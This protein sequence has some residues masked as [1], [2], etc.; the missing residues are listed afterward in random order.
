MNKPLRF[1]PKCILGFLMICFC[2]PFLVDAQISVG[3]VGTPPTC[4][5]FTN[6]SL[7][8]SASGG[9][10]PYTYTWSNGATGPILIGVGAGVYSVTVVDI[11]LA[12]ATATY[13]LVDPPSLVID[14]I[15]IGNVC[16]NPG[17]IRVNVSGGTAPYTY[18]WSNGSTS[19]TQ[20]GLAPGL[21]CVTV[22]DANGCAK[23]NCFAVGSVLSVDVQTV[24]SQCAMLCDGSAVANVSGGTP[25]YTFLWNTGSTDQLIAPLGP[26]TYTVTVTDANGCVVIGSGIVSE[27]PPIII[28]LNIVQPGCLS[29]NT[30]SI[31]ASATGGVPGYTYTWNTGQTGPVISNLG[32]GTYTLV[33]TD[34]N[35]CSVDTTV[36]IIPGND[37]DLQVT[38]T[39]EICLG[40][41]NGTATATA[42]GGTPP[43]TF[44]WS[45]G[46]SG[47][48]ITGLTPGTYTVTATDQ[49]GCQKSASVTVRAGSAL[50][51][52]ITKS[53]VTVCGGSDGSAS[54][55]VTGGTAP[56]LFTWSNGAT[57]ANITNLQAG[58]YS[59]TVVDQEGCSATGTVQI[60]QPT[61]LSLNLTK[62]D[63]SCFGFNNGTITTTVSGGTA[64][65]TFT[66]SNGANTAS[67]SNLAPGTYSVTVS[68]TGGCSA[69]GSATINQ[70]ASAL[71]CT[72]SVTRQISTPGGN[73]G[74]AAVTAAGGTPPYSNAW[75]NGQT[76]ANAT[77]L[78]AGT[79][80]VTVTDANRCTTV[81]TVTLVDPVP[82][83]GK[84]GDYVWEDK[85][86]NGLQDAT[87]P[88][89]RNVRVVLTGTTNSG[90]AVNRTTFTDVTGMYMFGDLMAG[91]YKVT[92][93]TPVNFA[94]TTQNVGANDAIDS[95]VASNGM[96]ANIILPPGDTNLTIDAGYYNLCENIISAG[97]IGYD[98]SFCGPGFDPAEIIPLSPPVGGSGQLEYLWMV[99]T[100]GGP[101]NMVSY[102]PIPGATGPSYDPPVI[103]QTTYYVRCT[104]R[105]NCDDYLETNIVAKVIRNDV[106]AQIMGPT[107][108]CMN[109]PYTFTAADAGTGATYTWDFGPNATPRTATGRTVS[110]FWNNFGQ[111]T[112]TLT[113]KNNK[114]TATNIHQVIIVTN[115][116][117]CGPS[118]GLKTTVINP[119]EV[120]V[121]WVTT[122]EKESYLYRVERSI[123]NTNFKTIGNVQMNG[124]PVDMNYYR[125]TDKTPK[126]GHSYYRITR[127]ANYNG[128][129]MLSESSEVFI[130]SD[131][132][133]VIVFP[134]PTDDIVYIERTKTFET[135]GLI[136]I[137]SADGTIREEYEMQK[138]DLLNQLNLNHLPPGVYFIKVRV[139]DSHFEVHR[140]VLE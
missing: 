63:I 77:G 88:P 67:L 83:L 44:A 57:A 24:D 120:L 36:A 97:T 45:N 103:Y 140:L 80:S 35:N 38:G 94:I 115:P 61:Q 131:Q 104:R 86:R 30:G 123:D 108:V 1:V 130:Y 32:P 58:T 89:I 121:E 71:T 69:T 137:L 49:A 5:G 7:E 85:N 118:I 64:P 9:W 19:D 109:L 76:S 81:C 54:A 100:I 102:Q 14:I 95:D 128:A 28:T 41:Q 70:P 105:V 72:A 6:G 73:D 25:P 75:S 62:T 111:R 22:T 20:T 51:L 34:A 29:G 132:N 48:V 56:Y 10:P 79:Y 4:P 65:Y 112:I 91:T 53:D 42:N 74:T 127:V 101:F 46:A 106:I 59:V 66:W 90:A 15:Q 96:T 107:T 18:L 136:S 134:N 52:T 8:A 60:N 23:V 116:D 39:D 93:T 138:E 12:I 119:T 2:T 21:Y 113:V 122:P 68:D 129:Q 40:Q 117:L 126:R 47:P 84:L 43:Y 92:F 124:N 26:G 82:I 110:V 50:M 87:E 31:S 17:D 139:D 135:A 99:S 3:I 55:S 78:A 133:D 16:T 98:E 27:P 125:F 114:C 13:T 11:D 33:V 37:L